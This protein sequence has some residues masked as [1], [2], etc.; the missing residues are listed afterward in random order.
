MNR[1]QKGALL[2]SL[3]GMG[4]MAACTQQPPARAPK[5]DAPPLDVS[6]EEY[7]KRFLD[8]GDSPITVAGGSLTIWSYA[9]F[10]NTCG[11]NDLCVKDGGRMPLGFD[12]YDSAGG[13]G[14][15]TPQQTV[16]TLGDTWT[17]DIQPHNVQITYKKA[18]DG[19]LITI[20]PNGGDKFYPE[21]LDDVF[22]HG[23]LHPSFKRIA[24]IV[25]KGP[26]S[27]KPISCP[28]GG[29]YILILIHYK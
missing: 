13:I 22:G 5:P 19:S 10:Y 17:I 11:A 18:D 29:C 21:I 3:L 6:M 27:S 1:K 7:K 2:F 14:S 4:L 25:F 16:G 20:H 26:V 28:N 9:G 15:A 23:R 24:K 8:D 12:V